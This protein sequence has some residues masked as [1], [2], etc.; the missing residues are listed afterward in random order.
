M[1]A[2]IPELL[3]K[4]GYIDIFDPKIENGQFDPS[5]PYMVEHN[6]KALKHTIYS[7]Y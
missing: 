4:F 5:P 3:N 1:R 7:L 2:T 6:A